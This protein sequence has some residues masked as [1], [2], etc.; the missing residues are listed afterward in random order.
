MPTGDIRGLEPDARV[1][2]TGRVSEAAVGDELLGRIIDGAVTARQQGPL[3]ATRRRPLNGGYPS[4]RWRAHR[5]A[6]R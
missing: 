4:T 6:N 2:P 1:V 5:S 3:H